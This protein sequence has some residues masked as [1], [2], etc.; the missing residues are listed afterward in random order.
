[1]EAYSQLI[2]PEA[3]KREITQLATEPKRGL[4]RWTNRGLI[5]NL[6]G[7]RDLWSIPRILEAT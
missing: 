4:T 7:Q 5:Y 2:H 3:K 1:M 6:L